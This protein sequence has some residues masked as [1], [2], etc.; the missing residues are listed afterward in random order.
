MFLE[1]ENRNLRSCA[2]SHRQPDGSCAYV[3]IQRML[4]LGIMIE[5]A[6]ITVSEHRRRLTKYLHLHGMSVAGKSQSDLC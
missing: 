6:P 3:Y 5:S 1:F 2:K 4:T